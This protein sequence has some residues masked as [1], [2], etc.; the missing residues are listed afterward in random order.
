MQ[1]VVSLF[2]FSA[3]HLGIFL[4]YKLKKNIHLGQEFLLSRINGKVDYDQVLFSKSSFEIPVH[5]S[6]FSMPVYINFIINTICF[7]FGLQGSFLLEKNS[8]WFQPIDY[9]IWTG[10]RLKLSKKFALEVNSYVGI[11]NIMSARGFHMNSLQCTIG[12]RYLF[13][14]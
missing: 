7:D 3:G 12:P 14:K 8:D 4:D 1:L 6:Y 9:G 10:L 5:L 2:I 11:F 13:D